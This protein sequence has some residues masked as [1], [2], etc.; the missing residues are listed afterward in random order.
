MPKSARY[1]LGLGSNLGDRRGNLFRAVVLL[2]QAGILIRRA[3]SLYRTQ[4]V[5]YSGQPWF[6]N[7]VL[8]VES[9][10]TPAELLDIVKNIER[11]MKREPTFRNG[12]RRIDIDILLAGR[13]VVRSKSL[14]V[15]HPRLARRNF[16]LRPL[17]EIAPDEVHPTLRKS[18]TALS[19]ESKDR[20]I[21]LKLNRPRPLFTRPRRRTPSLTTV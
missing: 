8:E 3:S 6:Y 14:T 18:V 19:A 10:L 7:Q 2:E 9:A 16:V 21:V 13:T 4:P 15:P 11:S 5:G 17:R 20:S 12:P 1:F